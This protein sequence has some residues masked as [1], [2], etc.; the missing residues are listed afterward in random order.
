MPYY[1]YGPAT[2][3]AATNASYNHIN[4][5]DVPIEFG[6]SSMASAAERMDER[7]GEEYHAPWLWV[8]DSTI[9]WQLDYAN[10]LPIDINNND[11]HQPSRSEARGEISLNPHGDSRSPLGKGM[12]MQSNSPMRMRMGMGMESGN[13]D[14]D[15]KYNPRHS[16]PRL[17]LRGHI[18]RSLK[19]N[20]L[21][22][23]PNLEFV[24]LRDNLISSLEG[25]ETE[26]GEDK[27]RWLAETLK[28]GSPFRS[29]SET[30]ETPLITYQLWKK[31]FYK[32]THKF[33]DMTELPKK[34]YEEDLESEIVMVKI[35]KCMEWLDFTNAYDEPIG[36]LGTLMEVEPLDQTRLEDV[37]LTN[38]N[39]SLSYRE[40]PSIDEPEPQFL[41]NF[42]S[43][44]VNLGDKRGPKSPIKPH[45]PDSFRMKVV[46]HLT[47]HTPPSPYVAH[48]HHKGMFTII[49]HV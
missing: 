13:G 12:G 8:C 37:G 6:G 17:D 44:D 41:P 25:I 5:C 22:L 16:P 36:I 29:D 10:P 35:P 43:L 49:A 45:S 23:S 33:D 26:A 2:Y 28:K 9:E 20:G 1:E 39:I 14:G 30:N 42:P 27:L 4:K 32:E 46:D 21:N 47:I 48:F 31:T 40:I 19:A 18:I 11:A 24:Y 3:V 15:G 38:H 34:A 7:S